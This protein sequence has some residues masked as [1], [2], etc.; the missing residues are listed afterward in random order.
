MSLVAF[1]LNSSSEVI[2][3]RT[4]PFYTERKLI[5]EKQNPAKWRQ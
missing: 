3:W 2:L 4:M 1:L 5:G